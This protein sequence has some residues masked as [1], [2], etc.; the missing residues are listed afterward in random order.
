MIARTAELHGRIFGT[1]QSWTEDWLIGLAARFVFAAVLL[2]Y[3]LNSAATK[4]G[5]GLFG[6]LSV[7]DNAYFQILPSVVEAYDYDASQVPLLPY[8]LVVT[9]GTYSEFLLPVLIVLGL[10]TRI[11]ALGMIGFTLV[12]SFVDITWHGADKETIGA[13]FDRFSDALILDQRAMWLFLLL[14]LVVRGPGRVSL[15]R[16]LATRR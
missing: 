5:E 13:W 7:A 11:A 12:Q 16:L 14:Y 3:Y 9:V 4:V 2:V 1:L 10:F 8:G 6:F 15:D